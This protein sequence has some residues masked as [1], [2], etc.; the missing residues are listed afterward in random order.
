[1]VQNQFTSST[2]VEIK[3]PPEIKLKLANILVKASVAR[4]KHGAAVRKIPWKT[5]S[6]PGCDDSQL[7]QYLAEIIKS[8]GTSRTLREVLD[9]YIE[10]HVKYERAAHPEHPVRPISAAMQYFMKHREKLRNEMQEKNPDRKFVPVS[11]Q[12]RLVD[13]VSLIVAS[14]F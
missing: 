5:V 12:I 14:H 6:I 1:M 4:L 3:D 8:T 9:V 10:N 13:K 7:K 11:C 2:Q